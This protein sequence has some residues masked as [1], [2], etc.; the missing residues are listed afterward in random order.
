MA[1]LVWLNRLEQNFS[2]VISLTE[3][4]TS[5]IMRRRFF[6]WCAQTSCRAPIFSPRLSQ[7]SP[8]ARRRE[9]HIAFLRNTL[10]ECTSELKARVVARSH[11]EQPERENGKGT[12][13]LWHRDADFQCHLHKCVWPGLHV[14]VLQMITDTPSTPGHPAF[15]LKRLTFS[16]AGLGGDLSSTLVSTWKLP[17]PHD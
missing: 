16:R 4:L 8:L 10:P 9:T 5:Y 7:S 3:L 6:R 13:L 11:N 2:P 12:W 17:H 14:Q 15:V 1:E